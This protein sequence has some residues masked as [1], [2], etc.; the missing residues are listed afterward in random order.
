VPLRLNIPDADFILRSSD[1]VNFRVRKSLLAMSSPFFDDLLSLPQPPGDELVDG[2]PVVQL[3]ENA[4]LLNSLISF[5]YPARR[6]RLASYKEVFALLNACQKY[7]MVLI[8]SFIRDEVRLGRF[9]APV[10]G[11]GFRAYAVASSMGLS[12]EMEHASRLTLGQPMT[13][14]SLGEGLRTFKGQALCELIRYRFANNSSNR[15]SKVKTRTR[16]QN[17]R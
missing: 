11:Q 13:F 8:Q 7:D 9:P 14:E 2:F 15:G 1:Q 10:Q 3:P 5:L 6:I 17:S 16:D 4:D 12:P